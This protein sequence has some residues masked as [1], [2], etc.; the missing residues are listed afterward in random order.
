MG[1]AREGPACSWPT[2]FA[3]R[4]GEG[5]APPI[6]ARDAPFVHRPGQARPDPGRARARRARVGPLGPRG[7]GGCRGAPRE[8]P[9]RPSGPFPP[10]WSP[11]TPRLKAW[12]IRRQPRTGLFAARMETCSTDWPMR[13]STSL[14]YSRPPSTP[15]AIASTWWPQGNAAPTRRWRTGPTGW[16]TTWPTRESGRVTT[17]GSTR[18]TV[19]SGWRRPGRSSNSGR[20]GSTSTT[21]T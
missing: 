3:G 16:P 7:T 5:S 19:W 17:S 11:T 4:L 9:S 2:P 15:S 12:C 14:N 10:R 20:C 1:S 18:A 13:H 6:L 21:A 8:R